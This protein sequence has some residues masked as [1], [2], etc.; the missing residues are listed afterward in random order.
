MG[1]LDRSNAPHC[2][3]NSSCQNKRLTRI[4]KGVLIASLKKICRGVYMF[5]K[6]FLSKFLLISFVLSAGSFAQARSSVQLPEY[7]GKDFY[8]KKTQMRDEELLKA[9][10]AILNKNL[11]RPP[12]GDSSREQNERCKDSSEQCPVQNGDGYR[13]AREFLFGKLHLKTSGKVYF[14]KE[15][16]CDRLVSSEQD[17][18]GPGLIPGASN[19][20]AEHTW[21]QSRFTNRYPKNLQK[22]DLH[23]LYPTDSK[24]NS[25]RSSLRFGRVESNQEDIGCAIAKLGKSAHGEFVFEPPA[26]HKG[27]VARALFYFAT[28]YEMKMSDPE[29]LVLRE[30]HQQ[31]P[32]DAEESVR[33]EEI[34]ALQKA[35]NPFIDFPE[36]TDQIRD[37]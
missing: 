20:N 10:N 17:N 21:P 31:D 28:R 11:L 8:M 15:V 19:L 32:V 9:L 35:R 2:Y 23:H 36:L 34:F 27:N 1:T 7:Y 25:K 13:K 3:N 30:W 22:T 37:F 5:S 12:T 26:H 6:E 33:N 18:I 29:E 16:Y 4:S 24:L 14:V